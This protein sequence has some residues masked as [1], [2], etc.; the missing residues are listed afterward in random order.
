MRRT[1]GEVGEAKKKKN[2]VDPPR[3]GPLFVVF[4]VW[5]VGG[6]GGVRKSQKRKRMSTPEQVVGKSAT[7]N[8]KVF[9]TGGETS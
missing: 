9:L 1:S 7:P 3:K 5:G 2:L 6:V 4:W 8:R